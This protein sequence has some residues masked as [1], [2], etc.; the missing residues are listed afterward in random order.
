M[1][2]IYLLIIGLV[3]VI[4]SILL[5]RLHP[6]LS[7][8]LGALVVS[9]LT[10]SHLLEQ[11]ALSSNLSAEETGILLKQTRGERIAIAFGDTAKSIGLL[12]VLASIMG[13]CLLESGAAERIVR[14]MVAVFGER[15]TP[16]AYMVSSFVLGIPIFFDTIFY[17]MIPLAR[18]MGVRNQKAYALCVMAI[19]AGGT[20]AHSLIP[21]TPG[22]LFAAGAFS[23]NLGLMMLMG[24]VVG[25][26][27]STIGLL[28]AAWLNK[29]QNIPL[30]TTADTSLD[31][32]QGWLNKDTKELP[33]FF[34]S[35]L[36]IVLP[37]ILI[38]AQT[39]ISNLTVEV[40][41]NVLAI[42]KQLGNPVI[43]LFLGTCIA[44]YLLG[45][46]HSFQLRALQKPV[47][48][49]I[50]SAGTIILITCMGGAFGDILQQTSI[51]TWLAGISGGYKLAALPLAFFVTAVIRTAQG[52]ATV[53]MI[54][55]VGILMVLN[56]PGALGFHPVYLAVVIGCGSKLFPWMNDSGFWII[57]KM[58]GFTE[59]ETIRNFSILLSIMGVT[60]L[61]LSMLLASIFPLI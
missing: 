20:M 41:D 28:Y 46:Q 17:L 1:S 51:G 29:R 14:T 25:F 30:R 52:S 22:P 43:A 49:A 38:A 53:A 42:S 12:I 50:G 3:I 35:N 39:I 15:K 11:Y 55:A 40:P 32:L 23:V 18:A 54:T 10:P 45:R 47:E 7:L 60:G 6:I 16:I 21:P 56:V 58:S 36:P 57:C 2:P 9:F 48:K 4:G 44:L 13:K 27:C 19:I 59:T 61:L 8:F 31:D 26:G 37:V 24:G 5:F 33:S 34:M